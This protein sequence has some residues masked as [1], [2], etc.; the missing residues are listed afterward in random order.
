MKVFP[1]L[2]KKSS[3]GAVQE[4][5]ISVDGSTII[6]EHGQSGGKIQK[7]ADTLLAGKNIG[8]KSETTPESQALS[9]AEAKW[10]KQKQRGYVDNMKSA[11]SGEVDAIVTGGVDPMLAQSFEKHSNKIKFPAFISR[12]LDGIRCIASIVNGKCSMWTRT[13]KPI[14]TLPNIVSALE[15]VFEGKTIT[16]DGEI[17]SDEFSG[18]FEK[19]VSL[20]R[21]EDNV[22]GREMLQYHIFDIVAEGY[23]CNRIRYLEE[24]RD[25]NNLVKVVEQTSVSSA[26]EA[27]EKSKSFVLEGYEGGMVKN[28]TSAYEFKRSYHIQKI[29]FFLDDEF[30]IVGV[31]E[32]R[33]KLTGHA[34]AFICKVKSGNEFNV[35][36]DGDSSKLKDYLTNFELYKGKMLTVRFQGLTGKAKVPRFPVGKSIRFDI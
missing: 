13:R 27:I 4:W 32:G 7:T 35:K 9:E 33:G 25:K 30:E 29:K 20:V 1:K 2:F 6:T 31:E 3:K 18:D 21:G 14:T 12:K 19:L 22:D 26:E 8:K 11:E 15:S 24:I 23:F 5:T 16:L 28:K 36:M 10:T 17:Y 34:G